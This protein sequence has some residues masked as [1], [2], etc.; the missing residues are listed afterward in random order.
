MTVCSFAASYI[1][2]CPGA[3]AGVSEKQTGIK[4]GTTF[5]DIWKKIGPNQSLIKMQI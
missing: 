3:Q 2:C 4:K 5:E 1:C